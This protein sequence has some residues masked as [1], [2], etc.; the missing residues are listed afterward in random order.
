MERSLFVNDERLA[1]ED[2]PGQKFS[3]TVQLPNAGTVTISFTIMERPATKNQAG[4]IMRVG[5][6]VVGRPSLMGLEDERDLPNRLLRQV[7]GE[8]VADSL[9]EDVTADWGAII[10]NSKAYQEAR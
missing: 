1:H 10:E 5:G 6:K 9:E 4:I 2:I 7:V 3:A 8:V